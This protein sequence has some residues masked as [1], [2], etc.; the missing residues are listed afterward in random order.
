[1]FSQICHFRKSE[2]DRNYPAMGGASAGPQTASSPGGSWASLVKSKPTAPV[3]P[4]S[5]SG[6]VPPSLTRLTSDKKTKAKP[7]DYF[8]MTD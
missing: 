3:A 1:M 6:V 7:V 4:S 2:L 5:R 8:D